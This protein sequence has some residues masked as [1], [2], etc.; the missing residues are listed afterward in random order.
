MLP[1]IKLWFFNHKNFLRMS[2]FIILTVS[3]LLVTWIFD[4]QYIAIK[5]YIPK[6]LLLSVEVSVNFLSNISGIFLT[7]STF[8]FTIIVTVLN[9]YS[10][11]ISPRLLQSFIDR[12][13]VL[14]LYGIFVSGFF[15]SV[16][17]ILLLQDIAPDQHV[18]AGS[19]GIAYAIIAM[20]SFI[21]F[22]RQV[23]DNLKVSN[24][25]EYIFNDCEK[26]I[27]KEVELREKAK[28]YEKGDE[29][30]KLSIVAENSGYLFE[31]KADEIFKELNGTRA[32]LTINKRIGEY[33]IKGE[34]IGELNIFQCELDDNDKNELKE[35]LSPLFLINVYNN[36]EEDYHRGIVNLTEVANMALSPGTNDPN[37]AI[38][39][40][41]KMSSLLGKLLSAGNHFIILKED[42]DVKIIYQSYS[43]EDELYLGFSQII[44]YS[45]GD[46]LVTKAILQGLYI[47]YTMADICAKKSIKKFFDD[48]YE[49]LIENFTH[50][51]HLETFKRIRNNME[52]QVS[53]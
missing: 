46:P 43:V 38:M 36:T 22:S 2:R 20:L 50:E 16:I 53:L 24:I 40:I 34:S 28:H 45:A 52:E 18:V 37:T 31:I 25:I 10:S 30:T 4:H 13:G 26:L 21:A 32:E 23:L 29:S 1:K 14:G 41:N 11:S 9:K 27:D 8:C 51:I 7:I 15:Y 12:T 33:T 3:L 39:C 48:S 47:I 35:K 42:E 19:F 17:S 5:S 44:S 6:Q 49:I